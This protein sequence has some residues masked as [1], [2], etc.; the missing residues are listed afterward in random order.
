M[1]APRNLN[2]GRAIASRWAL[3]PLRLLVSVAAVAVLASPP[4]ALAQEDPCVEADLYA[5]KAEKGRKRGG[6]ALGAGLVTVAIGGIL[7]GTGTALAL[8]GGGAVPIDSWRAG[9]GLIGV[10]GITMPIG[11]GVSIDG[12]VR[13]TIARSHQGK[14]EDWA[15]RCPG[16]RSRKLDYGSGS[17]RTRLDSA[18]AVQHV[19]IHGS[20]GGPPLEKGADPAGRLSLLTLPSPLS[21]FDGT[22][23]PRPLRTLASPSLLAP[24]EARRYRDPPTL[25]HLRVAA[26]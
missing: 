6:G 14:S 23:R 1:K 4:E 11:V 7:A 15:F 18:R 5:A 17:R 12:S 20:G 25:Y 13:L 8:G 24:V 21:A 16:P 9:L 26:R 3:A 19:A 2:P 10:G 22:I